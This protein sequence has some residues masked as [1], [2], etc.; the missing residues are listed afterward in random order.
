[1]AAISSC[2]VGQKNADHDA[3]FK[4]AI[5]YAR[6]MPTDRVAQQAVP[7]VDSV[8]RNFKGRISTADLAQLYDFKSNHYLYIVGNYTRAMLYADSML[9]ILQ[10]YS[11]EKNYNLAYATACLNKGNVLYSQKYY[12]SAYGWYY[13]G[14]SSLQMQEDSCSYNQYMSKVS[15]SLGQVCYDQGKYKQSVRFWLE[16]LNKMSCEKEYDAFYLTQGWYDN[17][18]LAYRNLHRPDEA[19]RYFE[20]AITLLK[21]GELKYTDKKSFIQ[22][23]LGLVYGN[24][25]DAYQQKAMYREA[26][27]GYQQSININSQKH[28]IAG[29]ARLSR[30]KLAAMYI[31]LLRFKDARAQLDTVKPILDK[32]YRHEMMLWLHTNA[33]YYKNAPDG[34]ASTAYNYLNSYVA[35]NDSLQADQRILIGADVKGEFTRLQ[36]EHALKTESKNTRLNNLLMYST[37]LVLVLIVALTGSY[38]TRKGIA[39]A[40]V[41]P[42]KKDGEYQEKEVYLNWF[43]DI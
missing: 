7:Y 15:A 40:L 21:A 20:K 36:Q 1:M 24:E 43:D 8:Y 39:Q 13:R 37:M 35:L 22:M 18:G 29:D 3:Y 42:K 33:E 25:A 28:Y 32:T 5:T 16:A 26:E 10:P 27:R 4:K 41:K 23:A 19:I 38:L 14:K 2:G 9:Y 11:G 31:K 12:S 34:N 17:I 30:L 6:H